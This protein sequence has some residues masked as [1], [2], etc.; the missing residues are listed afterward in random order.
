MSE[1]LKTLI[2]ESHRAL[3]R[4]RSRLLDIART[5]RARFGSV[6]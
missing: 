3:R 1:A 5:V 6:R 4:D 2:A